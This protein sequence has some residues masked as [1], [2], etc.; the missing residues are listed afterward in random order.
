[1]DEVPQVT[2]HYISVHMSAYG[3]YHLNDSDKGREGE[4][5][6]SLHPLH[7]SSLMLRHTGKILYCTCTQ[8]DGGDCFSVQ[9]RAMRWH[10][11]AVEEHRWHPKAAASAYRG[12]G[13]TWWQNRPPSTR[14]EGLLLQKQKTTR[15]KQGIVQ[16]VDPL[17]FRHPRRIAT[18]LE[19]P[20]F[21]QITADLAGSKEN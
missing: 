10:W 15:G 12:S 13:E 14:D 18:L 11:E 6:F 21:Y 3:T 17:R 7:K 16:S 20:S 5:L 2:Y 4:T 9:T 1:M 8:S 19:R